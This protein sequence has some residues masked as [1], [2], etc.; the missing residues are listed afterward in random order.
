MVRV[1]ISGMTRRFSDGT[2][3]GPIDLVVENGEL[4]CLLGPSGSGK[5]TTL[6]M[7][8]GLV[9]PDEGRILFDN[10]DTTHTPPRLRNI[11]MVFQ[12]PA[13]FPNMT[14]LQ[15]IAFG[16]DVRG[17]NSQDITMRVHELAD[18]LGIRHLLQRRV[19]EIS[20]GEA[21]RVA[22]ARALAGRP[23]L[24][25]LDEPLSSVDPVLRDRLQTEIRRIQ[26]ELG[27]TTIYVTHNQDEAFAIADR[28]AILNGG[29]VVQTGSPQ[30]LYMSPR[31]AFVAEF[32]GGGN[33]LWGDVVE[34]NDGGLRLRYNG[35]EFSFRGDASVGEKKRFTV[36][37]EDVIL[38]QDEAPGLIPG[39]ILSVTRQ[40]GHTRVTVDVNGDRILTVVGQCEEDALSVFKHGR[41]FISF[42]EGSLQL[43]NST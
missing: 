15:N 22:L 40:V 6:R 3:I 4:L 13:L 31:D 25:L 36:K 26:Q 20:G 9:V 38:H 14:V 11:G 1:E 10:V 32:I 16:P 12:S 34:S 39:T 17:W 5:T 29:V 21:Q 30:E 7:I 24:L 18:L 41:A 28:V 23:N 42:K 27:I 43:L 33:I 19:R 35:V 8:A 2:S 37:P